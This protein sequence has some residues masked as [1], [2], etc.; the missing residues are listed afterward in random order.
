MNMASV[1]AGSKLIIHG[2]RT[3]VTLRSLRTVELDGSWCV[4]VMAD[5]SLL[6]AAGLTDSTADVEFPTDQGPIRL[7]AEIVQTDDAFVLRVPGLRTAAMV[8]Q[9]RENVRGMVRLPLRGKV[10]TATASTRSE[11]AA[12]DE[13]QIGID[14]VEGTTYSVSGGGISAE[15][16]M[17]PWVDAGSKIYVE[18]EMPNGELAPAVMSV[19]EHEGQRVR[20]RFV[21]ISPLDRERL[22]RL[23]FARQRAELAERRRSADR[24]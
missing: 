13:P 4:P 21:D 24:G 10:L 22:V 7:D 11:V 2:G 15:V 6:Q 3:P 19:L 23:V 5:L 8:E 17:A 16:T 12:D 9:R 20:A 14:A 1:A 18:I